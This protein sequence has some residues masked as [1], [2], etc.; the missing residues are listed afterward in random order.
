M[1]VPQQL[2]AVEVREQRTGCLSPCLPPWPG[3]TLAPPHQRHRHRCYAVAAV[4]VAAAVDAAGGAD[5]W[6]LRGSRA[7]LAAADAAAPVAHCWSATDPAP[8]VLAALTL[9]APLDHQASGVSSITAQVRLQT[10]S[11]MMNAVD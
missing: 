8:E 1:Q 4:A 10:D 7:A 3:K 6:S 11:G 5:A 2:W 9:R